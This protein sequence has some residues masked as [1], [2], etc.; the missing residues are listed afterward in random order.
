MQT[1]GTFVDPRQR[2]VRPGKRGKHTSSCAHRYHALPRSPVHVPRGSLARS[3]PAYS[4]A[5][6]FAS[7]K[8]PQVGRRRHSCSFLIPFICHVSPAKYTTISTHRGQAD[9]GAAAGSQDGGAGCVATG[10][11]GAEAV[12]GGATRRQ[13]HS[14]TLRTHGRR[15]E[16]SGYTSDTGPV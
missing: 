2:R 10:V 5:H 3:P 1:K 6:I 7:R 8:F 9:A 14:L 4:M 13:R 15:L 12:D 11:C 16:A